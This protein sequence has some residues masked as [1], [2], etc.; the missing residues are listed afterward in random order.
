MKNRTYLFTRFSRTATTL[1][2]RP[3]TSWNA[4]TVGLTT[5]CVVVVLVATT[6]LINRV[7]IGYTRYRAEFL[8]AA[9]IRPGDDVSIAGVSVGKV[10]GT[11]LAGDRVIVEIRARDNVRLGAS[12]TAGIKLTTLLGSR[13]LE[14]KPGRTGA[15]T[16]RT[17]PLA[18]TTVPYDLQAALQDATSTF[19]QVDAEQVGTSL[20]VLSHQL[21]G[22]PPIVPRAVKDIKDLSSIVAKRRNEVGSLLEST[23]LITGT[24]RNQQASIGSLV[25][26]GRDVLAEFLSR[27]ETF[28][29][30][31][32]AVTGLLDVLNKVVVTDRAG[33]DNMLTSLKRMTALISDHDDYFRNLLQT[34]PI[35]LREVTNAFGTGNS[36]DIHLA[37]GFVV[38]SWMCAIS[39]R[40]TQLNVPQYFKDCK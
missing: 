29:R 20:T 13:Y 37:N 15:L 14:L 22:L 2:R 38:D 24:L 33:I 17:I 3:L 11:E 35:V 27:R 28:H 34:S 7:G 8:Q 12:T 1:L 25:S 16:N 40:A 36:I 30:M 18:Q 19:E 31:L 10:T 39:G 26:Q 6:L 32:S 23:A 9:Q 5:I 21:E 4:V